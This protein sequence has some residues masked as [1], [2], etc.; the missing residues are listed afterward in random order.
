MEES[1]SGFSN[2]GCARIEALGERVAGTQQMREG[3]DAMR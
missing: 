1:A 2:S 3:A